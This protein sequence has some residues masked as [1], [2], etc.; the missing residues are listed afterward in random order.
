MPIMAK[1]GVGILIIPQKPWEIVK[2]ELEIYNRVWRETNGTEPPKPL[3]LAF[4]FV[5]EDKTRAEE[6]GFK[7]IAAY[8]RSALKHYEMQSENSAPTKATSTTQRQQGPGRQ[9]ARRAGPRL[10]QADAVRNPRSGA[11]EVRGDERGDRPGGHD[12]DSW[13]TGECPTTRWSA[14]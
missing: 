1:L 6:V 14:T 7:Y 3:S 8:N 9:V 2:Q 13:A 4:V 11:G 5:D 10:R 12:G